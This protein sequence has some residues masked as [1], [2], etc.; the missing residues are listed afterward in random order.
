MLPKT[1]VCFQNWKLCQKIVLSFRLHVELGVNHPNG[2]HD[3]LNWEM[4]FKFLN[5]TNSSS[6]TLLFH[7]FY[8]IQLIQSRNIIQSTC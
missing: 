2:I 5:N 4:S 1:I 7:N 3:V 6:I 8:C